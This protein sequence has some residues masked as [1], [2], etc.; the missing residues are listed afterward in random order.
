MQ[1]SNTISVYSTEDPVIQTAV[2]MV[3]TST[4]LLRM[5]CLIKSP[6]DPISVVASMKLNM[7]TFRNNIV[8]FPGFFSLIDLMSAILNN[9]YTLKIIIK[10]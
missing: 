6:Q 7:L 1:I 9:R 4:I 10:T 8:M 5:Q 3:H 2:A